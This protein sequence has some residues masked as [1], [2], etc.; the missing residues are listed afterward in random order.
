MDVGG[1]DCWWPYRVNKEPISFQQKLFKKH[2][3]DSSNFR[4]PHLAVFSTRHAAISCDCHS[5]WRMDVEGRSRA[6][7]ATVHR[8]CSRYIH[9][10]CP[11]F[12]QPGFLESLGV[13]V[14]RHKRLLPAGKKGF[15]ESV[16]GVPGAVIRANPSDLNFYTFAED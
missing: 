12:V 2:P 8:G 14:N 10:R 5:D 15:E 11:A 9:R 13:G 16:E 6:L 4:S 3:P 1:T 7:Y